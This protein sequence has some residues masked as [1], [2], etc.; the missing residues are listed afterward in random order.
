LQN[1]QSVGLYIDFNFNQ[2]DSVSK[3]TF[4]N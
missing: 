2:T 1:S 4:T 3:I